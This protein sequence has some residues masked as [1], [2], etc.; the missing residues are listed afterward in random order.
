MRSMREAALSAGAAGAGNK[1]LDTDAVF[2]EYGATPR[3]GRTAETA[4]E[5]KVPTAQSS[6]EQSY[7]PLA[8]AQTTIRRMAG[9]MESMREHH[10]GLLAKVQSY[11]A[12]R[13]EATR[14]HY[15]KYIDDMRSRAD[16]RIKYYKGAAGDL[17]DRLESTQ[18]RLEAEQQSAASAATRHAEEAERLKASIGADGSDYEV[19]RERLQEAHRMELQELQEQVAAS[20]GATSQETDRLQQQL[21]AQKEAFQTVRDA[22]LAHFDEQLDDREAVIAQLRVQSAQLQAQVTA[23]STVTVAAANSQ[24]QSIQAGGGAAAS[25]LAAELSKAKSELQ[26]LRQ[27][28]SAGKGGWAQ[29]QPAPQAAPPAAAAGKDAVSVER[30]AQLQDLLLRPYQQAAQ[31]AE[32]EAATRADSCSA[33]EEHVDALHEQYKGVKGDIKTWLAEY[34]ERTGQD[35]DKE[36]KKAIRD[37]YRQYEA[38]SA[39]H[40]EAQQSLEDARA[41]GDQA[42][43]DVHTARRML[44]QAQHAVQRGDAPPALKLGTAGAAADLLAANEKAARLQARLAAAEDEAAALHARL[45]ARDASAD[46]TGSV[47]VAELELVEAELKR[48]RED[49]TQAAEDA[50]A[51]KTEVQSLQRRLTAAQDSAGD[52]TPAG[53]DGGG[54]GDGEEVAALQEELDAAQQERDELAEE[55]QAL[56]AAAQEARLDFKMQLAEAAAG[57]AGGDDDEEEAAGAAG[58]SEPPLAPVLEALIDRVGGDIDTAKG[59]WKDKKKSA[60]CELLQATIDHVLAELQP[61]Q[62]EKLPPLR[63]ALQ[64]AQDNASA[65]GVKASKAALELRKTLDAFVQDAAVILDEVQ[66]APAAPAAAA[67]K[68]KRTGGG[69]NAAAAAAIADLRA[70]LAAARAAAAAAQAS[71]GSDTPKTASSGG[72]GSTAV[73]TAQRKAEK[74]EKM[75]AAL[76]TQLQSVKAELEAA[77][78]ETARGGGARGGGAATSGPSAAEGKLKDALEKEKAK[79][80]EK[81]GALKTMKAEMKK[82]QSDL[83]RAEKGSGAAA[84]EADKEVK[85]AQRQMEADMKKA[86]K[87]ADEA[88]GKVQR[89]LNKKAAEADALAAQ[90]DGLQEQLAGM[91]AE[92]DQLK[93]QVDGMGELQGELE[94]MRAKAVELKEAQAAIVTLEAQGAELAKLYKEEQVKRKK[95]HNK[96]EDLKGKVR[97]YARCRPPNR[98]EKDLKSPSVVGFL[99]EMTMSVEAA[100]GPQKQFVYDQVFGPTSTQE[101][102]YSEMENLVQSAY[103]GFNVCVFAYGQTGSGKTFTMVGVQG[104]EHHLLGITPRAIAGLFALIEENKESADATVTCTMVEIYNDQLRDLF[105]L[106]ENERSGGR[107]K[108]PKL[109][110]KMD[111]KKRVFISGSQ[112]RAAAS[113]QDVLSHFDDGNGVRKVG[114]TK[115]NAESSRS[116]LVF[117]IMIEVNNRATGKTSMGKLTLVDLAGSERVGKTGADAERLREAQS[118]NRSL[119]ALGNVINA[120]ST[121]EA[122]D[123]K[124]GHV[125][126]RDN[127]LTRLLQDGLGGS[128]KTLMFVNVSPAEDNAEETISS[129]QYAERVKKITNSASKSEESKEVRRLKNIIR[130]LRKGE[131]ADD[132]DAAEEGGDGEEEEEEAAGAAAS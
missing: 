107:L 60:V 105:F 5:Q 84:S 106:V 52:A 112:V 44:Q 3:A 12:K 126:Y 109:D 118:I 54:G 47:P 102:V 51:A 37:E 96:L 90:A 89:D 40:K 72:G 114:S 91:T 34:K 86:A 82:L 110:I 76:K 116:H 75:N 125:P 58:G 127:L 69:G 121:A 85:R 73:R 98:R 122:E 101:Q 18:Q 113:P 124:V 94:A 120:L 14:E 57:A 80:K 119:A 45:D 131:A 111:K 30:E 48:A 24:Q 23:L 104:G 63:E 50:A 32:A 78:E 38:L 117:N 2:Q 10:A 17:R 20:G 11:Y 27:E 79:A 61:H 13:E 16:S 43:E 92:R 1:A 56:K 33:Q 49:A 62:H 59:L 129:L 100:H 103:D 36:A 68:P 66:G 87:A 28:Q 29:S 41:A 4:S 31:D 9:D 108:A 25:A 132:P 99:D 21:A 97:V 46:G 15:V 115:M 26:H 53:S 39:Q 8:V 22:L 83:A 95:L 19:L 64:T 81:E 67:P 77:K 123:G 130:R 7:I 6:K 128:A 71:G 42:Q 93:A 70:E 35:A 74:A 55:V 65:D 88:L